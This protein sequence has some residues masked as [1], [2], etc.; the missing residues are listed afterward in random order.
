MARLKL[1]NKKVIKE[2]R[3]NVC[4]NYT[5]VHLNAKAQAQM[6]AGSAPSVWWKY[7]VRLE[8]PES[9]KFAGHEPCTDVYTPHHHHPKPPSY[10]LLWKSSMEPRYF[11]IFGYRWYQGVVVAPSSLSMVPDGYHGERIWMF[12]QPHCQHPR[13][14]R[15]EKRKKKKKKFY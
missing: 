6:A 12:V 3:T 11:S 13:F 1:N 5:R 2:T 9:L 8:K 15:S 7:N 4:A 14:C 10:P